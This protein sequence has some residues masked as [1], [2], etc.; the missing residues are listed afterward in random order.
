MNRVSTRAWRA[1]RVWGRRL[2]KNGHS[3]KHE[4]RG[5]AGTGVERVEKQPKPQSAS[6]RD[7]KS[8][9]RA[10]EKASN[11]KV[12]ERAKS[13]VNGV[14]ERSAGSS[15][16]KTKSGTPTTTTNAPGPRIGMGTGDER[17]GRHDGGRHRVGQERDGASAKS[18]GR[19]TQEGKQAM[20]QKAQ[21]NRDRKEVQQLIEM[22]KSKGFLTYEEV[23]DAL[24]AD[25]TAADQMDD[26]MGALGDEDIEIVDAA[27]QVKIAPKRVAEEEAH[28]KKT[29]PTAR[30]QPQ[31][32]EDD[33]D[34]FYSK[35][36]DPVRMYL[37]KMGSV[38]LLTREGEV[39]IAKRIEQGRAR[40]L[41]RDPE[42]PRRRP[43]DHR[44]RRQAP[45]AQDPRQGDHPRRRRRE[46]RVRRGG[47]G[48]PHPAPHRQGEAP[49]QG[50][51]GSARVARG[52]R[53]HEARRRSRPRSRRT[54]R[55]WSRRSR[56]CVS[57]RRRIDKIVLKLRVAHPEGRAGRE[58][59]DRAREAHRRR[60]GAAPQGGA[61]REG[62]RRR[63]APLQAPSR[64]RARRG[65][66]E[67]RRG[68]QEPEEGRRGAAA[69]HQDA[70][71]RPTRTFAR[72][73]A[74]PRRRRRSSSKRTCASS[75]RSRRSTR[76]AASSSST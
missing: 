11:E 57:T 7:P 19:S 4:T 8:N 43:R 56:R 12:N 21:K 53:G 26:V 23:N 30:D 62:G 2:M 40:G 37:R 47:G 3:K 50:R 45:E 70:A 74:S 61:H 35:S 5:A 68:A 17:R 28:E 44:S 6:P 20:A 41:Q 1:L 14:P 75:S 60:H 25:M 13:H 55:R 58:R 16:V 52:G 15:G 32:K 31:A 73:S 46:R 49:R 33:G 64:R 76:T 36:N 48:P 66:H 63:R 72:G 34:G 54:A 27:T 9:E 51:P 18:T 22:G 69:R 38:S 67:P 10:N 24:P 59:V 71:P 42:Q 39:E 65:A 29:L